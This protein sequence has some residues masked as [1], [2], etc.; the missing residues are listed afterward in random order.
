M[1][2]LIITVVVVV[3]IIIL[4]VLAV[5]RSKK[6][7]K[8]LREKQEKEYQERMEAERLRKQKEEEQW[9]EDIRTGKV[10]FAEAEKYLAAGNLL[11][12]DKKYIEAI[13]QYDKAIELNPRY[14]DAYNNRGLA[15]RDND[16]AIDDFNMAL[17]Y[18]NKNINAHF[19]LGL[20]YFQMKNYSK[21]LL[22][23]APMRFFL[24]KYL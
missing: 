18:D 9:Q 14:V 8:L 4:I 17:R 1:K 12:Q 3:A 2:I 5:S 16:K 22:L 23:L 7:A 10:N 24:M 15:E 19:N 11:F 13:Q 21:A 20:T 6:K